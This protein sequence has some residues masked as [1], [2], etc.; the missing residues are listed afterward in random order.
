MLKKII[1][2]F[3]LLAT[4]GSLAEQPAS[5][6]SWN[7]FDRQMKDKI[8]MDR[9]E[10]LSHLIG[11]GLTLAG[12]FLGSLQTNESSESIA[13]ALL[14]NI[15]VASVGYGF[16]KRNI[17][18]EDLRMYYILRD[19]KLSVAAKQDF[20]LSFNAHESEMKRKNRN[21]RAIIH[22]LLATVN[23]VAGAREANSSVK[24]GLF[25]ISGVNA[26]ACLSFSFE[27]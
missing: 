20:L 6:G 3:T 14:Q 5:Q 22:G 1:L 16:Y 13:Y 19:S 26:L 21:M 2:L 24:N 17:G 12:G 9:R 25:F 15:G 23:G 8:E 4:L 18:D 11:G 7:D 10:G 27:F